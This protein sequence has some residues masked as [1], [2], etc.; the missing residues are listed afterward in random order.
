MVYTYL[1]EVSVK[2]K[3]AAEGFL[4]VLKFPSPLFIKENHHSTN[5]QATL[6]HQTMSKVHCV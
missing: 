2:Q 3:V 6:K 5:K 4:L 1:A